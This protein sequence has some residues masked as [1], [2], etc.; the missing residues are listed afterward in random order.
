MLSTR[1]VSRGARAALAASR[2]SFASASKPVAAQA[3]AAAPQQAPAFESAA[4]SYTP[5]IMERLF[6]SSKASRIPMDTP[7]PAVSVQAVAAAAGDAPRVDVSAPA[8]ISTLPSGIRVATL[9]SASPIASVGVFVDGGSRF[10]TPETN[11]IT[12]FLELMSLKSTVNRSDFRL[13]RDMLKLGA[14][15]SASSGREHLI[16]SADCL[17]EHVPHV[18]GTLGD[19]IQHHAFDAQEIAE[20]REKYH[21]AAEQRDAV[22]DLRIMEAVHEAAYNGTGLGLS[23]YAPAHNLDSFTHEALKSFTRQLFVPKRMVVSAVGVDHAELVSLT[24]EVFNSLPAG[25][26]LQKQPAVYTG[27]EVRMHKRSSEGS[28]LTHFALAFET[29]SWHHKD[30]V[31][32]CVLQMMMGGGGSFSAGGPGKG[33]YSR[34]YSHVLNKYDW[35]ESCTCFNSIFTDTSLFG[36]YGTCL[37]DKAGALADVMSKELLR[38]A[39]P[40]DATEL[41]RA[42]NQL[43]SA[44]YMQLESRTLK[45]E[46]I[47]R[48]VITYGKVQTA[49]DISAQID[50]VTAEDIARVAKDMLKTPVT[51]AAAGDLTSLPRYEQIQRA[52]K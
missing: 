28:G 46:D 52:F 6:S 3:A 42:K 1:S 36:I 41:A 33:M 9:N 25:E 37:P 2:R 51:I 39:G 7:W 47:G 15:V 34:L 27:G 44:V 30:L 13:V 49:A 17:T 43:R 32:M 20:E 21:A 40:I 45:L 22:M 16:Y 11:G 12:H 5:S 18:L 8:Q 29:A 23:L 19:V 14:N 50:A 24:N 10:E 4:P 26:G 31:A 38:M 35:A 48:Q